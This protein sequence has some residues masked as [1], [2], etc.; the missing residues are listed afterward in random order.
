MNNDMLGY[1]ATHQNRLDE[2]V[3]K[4]ARVGFPDCN[5]DQVQN[6]VAARLGYR[7]AEDMYDS[8]DD[9]DV[10]YINKELRRRLL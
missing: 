7:D 4:L 6:A 3:E 2:I 9:D 5:T 1:F 8:L 10:A